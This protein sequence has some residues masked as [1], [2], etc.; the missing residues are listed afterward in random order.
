[1]VFLEECFLQAKEKIE[2]KLKEIIDPHT[3]VD[4]V[5]MGLIKKIEVNGKNAKIV[6]TPT[7]PYCPITA[8]FLEEI[9]KKA[10]SLKE[11]SKAEVELGY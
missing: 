1:M 5:S 7:T 4:I 10:E 11:I 3:G 2:K 9:K 6:F 8:F